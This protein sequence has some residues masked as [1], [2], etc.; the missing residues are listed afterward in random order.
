MKSKLLGLMAA[1][2]SLGL[3]P[4]P[5]HALNFDF[6]FS[7]TSCMNVAPFGG[8]VTGEI[9]GLTNGTSA[10]TA[11]TIGS[12]PSALFSA[13]FTLP[14]APFIT[15]PNVNDTVYEN[16]FTVTGGV[17]TA[18]HFTVGG[19]FGG[20]GFGL[21]ST[22]APPGENLD[23][24]TNGTLIAPDQ[25]D[26]ALCLSGNGCTATT[27][28]TPLADTGTTPLPAALPLF[29]SGLGALG[30]LGWRRKRKAQAAA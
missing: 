7:C 17:I 21:G 28:F 12:Y 29:A 8:T 4:S 6:S 1:V 5:G 3:F 14:P 27:T 15:F 18:Y 23:F 24:L 30:L 26:I 10:A 11:V 2:A 25:R 16:T 20:W 22:A 19:I 9:D 13:S